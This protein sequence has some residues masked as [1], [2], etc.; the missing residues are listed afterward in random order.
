MEVS[1]LVVDECRSA[2]I[3]PRMNISSHMVHA[4]Q[5]EEQKLKQM[6]L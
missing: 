3:I 5:I 1:D 2:M 4:E 6:N